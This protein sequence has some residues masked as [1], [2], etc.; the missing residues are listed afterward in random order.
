MARR[1]LGSALGALAILLSLLFLEPLATARSQTIVRQ[2]PAEAAG[3]L[4][5]PRTRELWQMAPGTAAERRVVSGAPATTVTQASFS[6]DGRQIA[7]SLFRFFR[8]EKPA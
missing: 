2:A 4:L 6:P 7:Y 8:P 1:I 5:L 3:R